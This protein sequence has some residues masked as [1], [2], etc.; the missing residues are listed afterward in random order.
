MIDGWQQGLTGQTVG[1]Q[2][3]LIVPPDLGY[4]DAGSG[5]TIPGGATLVFVVDILAALLTPGCALLPDNTMKSR[6]IPRLFSLNT[7]VV[8]TVFQNNLI[9]SES[10]PFISS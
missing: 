7:E 5:D 6:G 8:R 3:L 1:S 9:S 2:V 4:G 10:V